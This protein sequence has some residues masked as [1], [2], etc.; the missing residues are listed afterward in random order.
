MTQAPVD[1]RLLNGLEWRCIGPPRGGRVVA[2]AG[3]PVNPA[4]FYFG[5]VAGGV[6]K[7][8][9]G[10][11]YWE[12]VSDGYFNTSS[13]GAIAVSESDPNVVYAGMGEACIRVVPSY[14]DG[15]Y[16]STDAGK[17]WK[18]M[19]LEDTR[20]IGRVRVHP[21]NPD[22]VYVA[23]LGHAFGPNEQRG[24]FR[25]TDG[26]ETWE[27]VLFKSEDAGAVDLSMDPSNPRVL[28][29]AVWQ[30]RRNF[31]TINSGGPDCGLYKSTDGGDTWTDISE[32][33]GLPSGV[34][35]RIGVAVS[36]AK[37]GRVWA[38]VESEECGIYRSDDAGATWQ[39]VNTAQ[40]L[41]GRP[42]Y[43]SHIFA[44]PID[45]ETVWVLNFKCWKSTDGGKTFAEVTTPHGDNHDLWIDPR[46]PQRMIESNDGG[47]TV[48][49]NGGGLVVNP[50][51]P[52]H[53]PVLPRRDRQSLPV[54]G[55]RD[56]AGQLHH[57]RPLPHR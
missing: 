7:T 9:D 28:Y 37:P 26:G 48:T 43:Y 12:N 54:Q 32:N 24:V 34:K 31:W 50:V 52:A 4:V 56:A 2:V 45:S 11:A 47:A 14:G 42:W 41:H 35:G 18:H 27:H 15:V 39:L 36:P 33:P 49:F 10:G 46:N 23:A 21:D 55:L 53:L 19:G 20:H 5:A 16:R 51:Q 40:D 44:D 13:V 30:V 3:D 29:A 38:S 6:W 22:V 25:S 57:Q 17:T 8:Y 1:P